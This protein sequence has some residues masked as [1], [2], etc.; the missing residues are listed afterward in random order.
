ML[1]TITIL[2]VVPHTSA[3]TPGVASVMIV[4]NL[5]AVVIGRYAIQKKGLG[6]SLPVPLPKM[7][8]GFGV[9]ELLATA[10]FGHLL[11]AGMILGLSQSGAF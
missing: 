9:A 11:G 3:W 7:F 5:F 4:C 10:S 2:A 8:E 1:N 6:P